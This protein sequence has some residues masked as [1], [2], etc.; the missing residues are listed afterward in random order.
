M[1]NG[2]RYAS[3]IWLRW[4]FCGSGGAPKTTKE[5]PYLVQIFVPPDGLGERLDEML[6]FHRDSGIAPHLGK[7]RRERS[8]DYL[9]WRFADLET[10][11]AFAV[12]FGGKQK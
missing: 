9:R 5:F 2:I 3:L 7:G 6:A 12:K 10:A 4:I 8:G 1:E 11:I